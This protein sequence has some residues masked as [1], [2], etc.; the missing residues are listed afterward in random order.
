M[1][2]VNFKTLLTA[3]L[4]ESE[5]ANDGIV[6]PAMVNKH[7]KDHFKYGFVKHKVYHSGLGTTA[8]KASS[9]KGIEAASHSPMNATSA[10]YRHTANKMKEVHNSLVQH[11]NGERDA[12]DYDYDKVTFNRGTKK[13]FSTHLH[14]DSHPTY[15]HSMDR[16]NGYKT[17]WIKVNHVKA[18]KK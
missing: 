1:S 2:D 5:N 3:T 15:H 11:L 13:E 18:S 9:E 8:K 14:V 12:G 17:D 7:L 16:D 10:A 4:N 6:T